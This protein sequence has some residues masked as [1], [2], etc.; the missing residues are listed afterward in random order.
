MGE[1]DDLSDSELRA[2]L[3]QRG[4]DSG[5]VGDLVRRRDDPAVLSMIR[6]YLR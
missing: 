5:E 4:V 6:R 2:R 3:A 1:V